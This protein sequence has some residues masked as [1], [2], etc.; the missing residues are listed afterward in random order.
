M[1]CRND[2]IFYPFTAVYGPFCTT[3]II[4]IHYLIKEKLRRQ[5]FD[6]ELELKK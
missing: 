5:Q 2:A 1:E 3:W 4:L 6:D